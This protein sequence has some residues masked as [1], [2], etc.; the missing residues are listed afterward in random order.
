MIIGLCIPTIV[1]EQ[2]VVPRYLCD[3]LGWQADVLAGLDCSGEVLRGLL[4]SGKRL[5][6]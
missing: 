3:G 1:L 2:H 4:P 5:I 6:S